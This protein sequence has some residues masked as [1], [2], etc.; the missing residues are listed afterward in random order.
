MRVRKALLVPLAAF[1]LGAIVGA[2]AKSFGVF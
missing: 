1:V 2:L